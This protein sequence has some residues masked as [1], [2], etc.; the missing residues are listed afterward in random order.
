M[1]EDS[2]FKVPVNDPYS[3]GDHV[4]HDVKHAS[5]RGSYVLTRGPGRLV[6]ESAKTS[7]SPGR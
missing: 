6:V 1:N 7:Q 4:S 5:S 2:E 3:D